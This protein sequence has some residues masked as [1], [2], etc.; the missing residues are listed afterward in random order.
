M[1]QETSRMRRRLPCALASIFACVLGMGLAHADGPVAA[2]TLRAGPP[3]EVGTAV[4]P[5]R[6][7]EVG[8]EAARPAL[9]ARRDLWLGLAAVGAGAVVATQDA[10]LTDE[11]LESRTAGQQS[12]ADGVRP[13]GDGSVVFSALAIGYGAARLTGHPATA[14]KFMRVGLSVGVASLCTNALKEVVGRVRPADAPG[15]SDDLIP[16]S[17]H[18]SFPSGHTTVAFALASAIDAETETR[19]VPWVVYPAAAL[20]GWSRVHDNRHWASDV[21]AGAVI[22]ASVAGKTDRFLQVRARSR[23]L[24]LELRSWDHRP[25][26]A[27][28]FRH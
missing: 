15:D 8:H 20:V 9:F 27:L 26:L 2:D 24:G 5:L 22:G 28:T 4:E 19:W 3:P 23:S 11:A 10:W 25:E 16:F 6:A 21:F 17:G 7:T 18:D 1:E 13:F 14:S 12:L